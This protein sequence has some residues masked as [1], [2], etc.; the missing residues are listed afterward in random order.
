MLPVSDGF[1]NTEG[2]GK[3][4]TTC[5]TVIAWRARCLAAGS[6]ELFDLEKPGRLRR[7][8]HRAVASATLAP[9]PKKLGVTPWSCRL[10][11]GRL[12][13]DHST[14]AKDRRECGVA[15]WRAGTVMF[16][17]SPHRPPPTT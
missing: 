6:E 2:V 3:V 13:I 15:P 10:L 16:S 1:S 8:D 5:T 14:V 9:P 7:I 11:T 4:G 17:C 12:G